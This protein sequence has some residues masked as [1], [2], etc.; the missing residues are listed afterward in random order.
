MAQFANK[1]ITRKPAIITKAPLTCFDTKLVWD[2]QTT[3]QYRGACVGAADCIRSL[4]FGIYLVGRAK[5]AGATL[6]TLIGK[7]NYRGDHD[8]GGE[9][10][11]DVTLPRRIRFLCERPEDVGDGFP[12]CRQS[13]RC[14]KA[15]TTASNRERLF[16]LVLAAGHNVFQH[17]AAQLIATR[18]KKRG[19]IL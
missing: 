13:S 18:F 10:G 16:L 7:N 4:Y 3:G 15:E 19:V 11:V 2:W 6:W 5:W 9:K 12:T 1:P 17:I 8:R 14:D